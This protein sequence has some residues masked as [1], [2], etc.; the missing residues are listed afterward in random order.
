MAKYRYYVV[1]SGRKTGIFGSYDECETQ[2]KNFPNNGYRGVDSLD[3]A[4]KL[5][6]EGI[7]KRLKLL[8]SSEIN[9][10]DAEDQSDELSVGE[11]EEE[12]SDDDPP[13]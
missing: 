5:L 3:E 8:G 13:F 6:K 7:A 4:H 12:Y 11:E 9:D 1:W 2:V 10:N